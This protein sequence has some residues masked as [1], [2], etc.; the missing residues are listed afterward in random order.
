LS[1]SKVN[2]YQEAIYEFYLE[3]PVELGRKY[4]SPFR[5]DDTAPSLAFFMSK[6]TLLFRDFGRHALKG[7]VFD[8]V[9]HLYNFKNKWEAAVQINHDMRLGFWNYSRIIPIKSLVAYREV[10]AKKLDPQEKVITFKQKSWYDR[11]LHYWSKFGV[12]ESILDKFNTKT[13]STVYINGRPIWFYELSNP[14]YVYDF[15]N[16]NYK[17]YRPFNKILKFIST[18][19]IH[20]IFQGYNQL[21]EKAEQVII[22]KAQKDVMSLYS[23]GVH[24]IAPNS[25]N[26]HLPPEL[27]MELSQRFKK[28][29][30]V[31]DNDYSKTENSGVIR[32]KEICQKYSDNSQLE[33]RVIPTRFLS[34]DLAE[35]YENHGPIAV[36]TLI[37]EGKN[38]KPSWI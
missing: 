34:T 21:P 22:T 12:N 2:D 20:K 3:Q 10:T 13:A 19:G 28:I 9:K 4:F 16:K 15:G 6:G 23:L 35:L 17:I 8:F 18:R 31:F 27:M 33:A 11:D 36:K 37:N 30:L 38:Y 25:E 14:I 24:A 32:M 5:E 26:Y 29:I 7:D 1:F